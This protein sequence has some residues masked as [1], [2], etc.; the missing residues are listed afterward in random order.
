VRFATWQSLNGT[1]LDDRALADLCVRWL[2][3][4]AGPTR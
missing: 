4:A 2:E 3:A 1:G